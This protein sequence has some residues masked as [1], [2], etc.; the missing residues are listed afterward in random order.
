M[1][2]FS[3]AFM[4]AFYILGGEGTLLKTHMKY[5]C[6]RRHQQQVIWHLRRFLYF[7]HSLSLDYFIYYRCLPTNEF[8]SERLRV[9]LHVPCVQA[10][11]KLF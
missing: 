4:A 10:F 11:Y 3:R 2:L 1:V 8:I 9:Q 6:L 7:C 5:L